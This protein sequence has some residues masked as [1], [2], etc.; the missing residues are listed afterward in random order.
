MI[1]KN[2]DEA[3]LQGKLPSS[4]SIK[5]PKQNCRKKIN[6]NLQAPNKYEDSSGEK[7]TYVDGAEPENIA[8]QP[9]V[10]CEYVWGAG[11]ENLSKKNSQRCDLPERFLTGWFYDD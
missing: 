5:K 4:N 6:P 2:I 9:K 3:V 8:E 11:K 7:I 10:F 1:Y